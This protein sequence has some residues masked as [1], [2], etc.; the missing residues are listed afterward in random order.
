LDD[1]PE[2]K[3]ENK[4]VSVFV[5]KILDIWERE[6]YNLS[7]IPNIGKEDSLYPLVLLVR[8]HSVRN[9]WEA[10]ALSIALNGPQRQ[11]KKK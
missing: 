1:P 2:I 4:R 3:Y 9:R 5:K 7:R 10:G 8:R 6:V 11:A